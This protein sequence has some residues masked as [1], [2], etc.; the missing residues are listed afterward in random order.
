MLYEMEIAP[1]AKLEILDA[2]DWVMNFLK[3]LKYFLTCC[4]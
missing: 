2:Y 3:S 4:C 1:L